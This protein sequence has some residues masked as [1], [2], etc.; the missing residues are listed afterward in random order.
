[1]DDSGIPVLRKKVNVSVAV[2]VT[3]EGDKG[4]PDCQP[5]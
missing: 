5:S 1:M 3:G 2:Q 4:A